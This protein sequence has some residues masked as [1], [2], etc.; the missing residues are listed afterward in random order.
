MCT[1]NQRTTKERSAYKSETQHHG[2]HRTISRDEEDKKPHEF[3][4]T[5]GKSTY[6]R[7]PNGQRGLVLKTSSGKGLFIA[8]RTRALKEEAA[9]LDAELELLRR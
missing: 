6:K 2:Q 7:G 8:E 3:S 4:N 1:R 9:T 5:L